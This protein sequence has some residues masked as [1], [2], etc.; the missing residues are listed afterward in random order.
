ME[1]KDIV[2]PA[3]QQSLKDLQLDYL[4]LYLIHTPFAL[5]T[6]ITLAKALATDDAKLGYDPD[7]TAR[8]WEVTLLVPGG[9]NLS[10]SLSL[11]LSLIANNGNK[12][13]SLLTFQPSSYS[14]TVLLS[15]HTAI[16]N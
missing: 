7:R 15:T 3:C 12:N 13:M 9:Y 11:S 2:L 16:V 5:S 4:D 6:G 10:L 14:A 1:P 8:T